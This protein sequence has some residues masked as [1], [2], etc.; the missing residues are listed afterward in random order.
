[1]SLMADRISLTREILLPDGVI[2]ISIDDNEQHHLRMLM[3][4]DFGDRNFVT[5]IIWQKNL[6]HKM[7]QSIFPIITIS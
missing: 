2:F 3:D 4:D 1:M 7:M 6:V 5:N